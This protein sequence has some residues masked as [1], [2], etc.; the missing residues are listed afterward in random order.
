[1]FGHEIELFFMLLVVNTVMFH[2]IMLKGFL[3]VKVCPMFNATLIKKIL[4]NI[5]SDE[6]CPDPVPS[7]VFEA[8]NSEVRYPNLYLKFCCLVI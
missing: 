3:L 5:V 1:M 8:L 4:D 2:L 7:N 6:L